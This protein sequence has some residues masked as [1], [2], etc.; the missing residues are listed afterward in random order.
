[1]SSK[2]PLAEEMESVLVV[3][4]VAVG[5]IAGPLATQVAV[6]MTAGP[7]VMQVAVKVVAQDSLLPGHVQQCALCG[8]R[9]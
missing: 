6:G 4:Q 5:M 9:P 8:L 7:L 1:M 3:M 2:L